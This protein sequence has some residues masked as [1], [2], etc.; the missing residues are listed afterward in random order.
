MIES[1]DPTHALGATTP[2]PLLSG[3]AAGSPA[4]PA[5]TPHFPG[6]EIIEEVSPGVGGM[7]VVYKAEQDITHQPV[8]LKIVR[9][10]LVTRQLLRRFEFETEVLGRLQHP[11]IARIYDADTADLGFGPQPFFHKIPGTGH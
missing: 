10:L 6:V 1:D 8:A 11:G 4:S 5:D 9:P 7:G 2:M 3:P